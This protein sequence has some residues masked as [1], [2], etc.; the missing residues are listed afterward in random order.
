MPLVQFKLIEGTISHS[1]KQV[2]IKKFN[3]DLFRLGS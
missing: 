1:Q 3:S 2:T